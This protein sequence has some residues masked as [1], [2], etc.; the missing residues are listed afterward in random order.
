MTTSPAGGRRYGSAFTLIELMIVL[1]ILAIVA[2]VVLPMTGTT[3]AT[4][5]IGA[6]RLLVADIQY[7]QHESI[8]HPDDPCLLKVDQPGNRYWIA[9]VS[10]ADTPIAD[11][12]SKGQ[13][14]VAFGS[15]RASAL[16]GVTM[17]SYSLGGDT[18]L[19][20][21][22][23]GQPDQTTTA[24]IVLTCGGAT[25]TVSVDPISGEVSVQ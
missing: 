10:A 13:F 15:G 5:L 4:Q 24:T 9:K 23:F 14:L 1:V 8:T 2:A 25:L 20:F 17:R 18:E 11:P 6:G 7:A 19:R 12:A 22:G 21:D 3:A 16:A